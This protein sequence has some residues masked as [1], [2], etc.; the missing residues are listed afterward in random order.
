MAKKI[1]LSKGVT[2]RV[3]GGAIGAFGHA[4]Y[5]KWLAGEMPDDIQ[6]YNNYVEAAIGAVLPMLVKNNQIVASLGDGLMTCGLAAAISD[7]LE[8]S[9]S[10]KKQDSTSGVGNAL[11]ARS[12]VA[13]IGAPRRVYPRFTS[14]VRRISGTPTAAEKAV[15]GVVC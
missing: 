2:G 5:N 10:E 11:A 7:L 13:G 4:A 12:M 6:Q 14:R 8:E 9:T 1:K 3:I 15:S